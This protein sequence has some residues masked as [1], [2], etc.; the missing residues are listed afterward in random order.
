VKP[1]LRVRRSLYIALGA[2]L[3]HERA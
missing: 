2:E 3:V 1:A